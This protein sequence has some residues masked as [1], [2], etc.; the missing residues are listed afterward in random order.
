MP[1]QPRFAIL[2][3]RS[4]FHVTWQC[5]NHDW[6]L[7][8]AWA[9]EL[10]YQ[11]LLRYKARYGVELYSYCLM[12]NHPHLSGKLRDLKSFSD[13]FRLVNSRFAR[14]YNQ[15]MNRRGQVVMDRFKSPRIQT[16]AD[17]LKVMLY[18][19]LN[20]KRAGKARHPRANEYSSFRYYAYGKD[21][22]LLTP[23]PSYLELGKTPKRRQKCYQAMIAEILK[24]D[25]KEKRPYSSTPFIGNPDW[26]KLK[27][28]ELKSIRRERYRLWKAM[29]RQRFRRART[30]A[31]S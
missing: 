19:D 7:G 20:P 1:S 10:Y 31:S 23:A 29:H 13:F 16:D 24:N 21:D 5:H 2:E 9:K 4:T 28:E 11:L 6:L 14:L 8:E 27:I 30:E 18:I 12:D 25:W 17:L 26:V 15:R 3:D 22:P